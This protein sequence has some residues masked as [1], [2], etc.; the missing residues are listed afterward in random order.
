MKTNKKLLS[1]IALSL[2]LAKPYNV[3][4]A[5]ADSFRTDEYYGMDA[6][7][8]SAQTNKM[9]RWILLTLLVL[10]RKDTPAKA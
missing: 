6:D 9:V 1:L 7:P 5:D 4:A 3:F 8:I 2:L 10:M